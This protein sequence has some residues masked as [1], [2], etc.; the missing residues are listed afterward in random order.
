MLLGWDGAAVEVYQ[1]RKALLHSKDLSAHQAADQVCK[2][3]SLA[4][5]RPVNKSNKWGRITVRS[6]L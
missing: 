2:L 1:S 6:G 4:S 5:H 3:T